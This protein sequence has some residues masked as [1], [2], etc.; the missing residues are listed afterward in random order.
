MER[1]PTVGCSEKD[2]LDTSQIKYDNLPV[3]FV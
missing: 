1:G 2:V 3:Y